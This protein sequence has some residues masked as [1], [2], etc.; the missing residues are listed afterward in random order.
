[1]IADRLGFFSDEPVDPE[2]LLAAKGETVRRGGGSGGDDSNVFELSA[3]DARVLASGGKAIRL[4]ASRGKPAAG[5]GAE[6][7]EL[8]VAT[9]DGVLPDK[10]KVTK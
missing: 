7:E 8:D 2:A 4:K 3:V 5:T 9:F 6:G 10:K 1:M